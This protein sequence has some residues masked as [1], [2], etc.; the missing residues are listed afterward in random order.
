MQAAPYFYRYATHGPDDH[1]CANR[2]RFTGAEADWLSAGEREVVAGLADLRRRAAFVRGRIAA[3]RLILVEY[4][5]AHRLGTATVHPADIDIDSGLPSGRRQCPR[6][7][8]RRTAVALVAVDCPHVAGGARGPGTHACH[9][10]GSRPGRA[11]RA[12]AM[13][14]GSLVHGGRTP[15]AA[16]CST[17]AGRH[18]VGYEGSGL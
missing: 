18:A 13:V 12:V 2:A 14:C 11:D 4:R 6:S 10:R 16:T 3:K 5:A 17:R 9:S 15:L 1:A 8:D 7:H